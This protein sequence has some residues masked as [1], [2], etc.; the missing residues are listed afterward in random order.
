MRK[1]LLSLGIVIAFSQNIL[2]QS[3]T[4]DDEGSTQAANIKK[5][6]KKAKYGA[7]LIE[8]EITFGTGK[9]LGNLPIV[10]ATEKGNVEMAA[11]EDKADMGYLLP[12]NQF[13]KLKDYDFDIFYK[14]NFKSQKYQPVKVSLTSDAIYLDD[15]Y[16]EVYGF[17]A[18]QSGQRCRFKYVY[19][20]TDSKYLTRL[21]FHEQIPIGKKTISFKVPS[22]LQLDIQ[23]MNFAT[24]SIKKEVKKE[25]D[26]TTYTF[27]ASNLNSIENEPISLSKPY[28]LPHLVIT[29][30]SFSIDQKQYN[31]FKTI[32]D[33]YAWYNLLYKKANNDVSSLKTSVQQLIAGKSTD[34]EKIK[35]I[36]Y[37]VQDNIRYIAFEEGYSGFIPQTV[38]E[39]YK[40]KYSDCKGMA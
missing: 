31:G 25:K 10:T 22:W 30:R 3:Q 12:Y 23:E 40:N 4:S 38:Q 8:K 9:G 2:A 15:S 24:Y 21:F 18:Q 19:E 17:T 16:G 5:I 11:V 29:V 37:W 20:Y 39:V 36:Y 32:N 28:Y 14:N 33:M 7:Y 13:V 34:E 35:S 6:N 27:S 26:I 1:A